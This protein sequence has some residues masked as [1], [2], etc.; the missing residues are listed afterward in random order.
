MLPN[1]ERIYG[2]EHREVASAL[3]GLGIAYGQLGDAV[4]QRDLLERSLRL[5]ERALGHDHPEVAD[6][7]T[8]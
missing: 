8:N 6:I 2:P 7:M 5:R 3:Q 1:L 4:K